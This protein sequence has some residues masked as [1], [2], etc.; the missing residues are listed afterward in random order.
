MSDFLT[1]LAARALHATPVVQPRMASRFEAPHAGQ[2]FVSDETPFS[3]SEKSHESVVPTSPPTSIAHS[4]PHDNARARRNDSDASPLRPVPLRPVPPEQP[5]ANALQHTLTSRETCAEIN[6]PINSPI[7]SLPK[8]EQPVAK[9]LPRGLSTRELQIASVSP[10]EVKTAS[11]IVVKPVIERPVTVDHTARSDASARELLN[12]PIP[13]QSNVSHD[14][15]ENASER[16]SSRDTFVMEPVKP[17]PTAVSQN[18][19]ETPSHQAA[20]IMKSGPLVAIPRLTPLPISA[21]TPSQNLDST[22]AAPTIRVTIG[23]VEVRAIL[24]PAP[25]PPRANPARANSVLSLDE[26]LKQRTE[27]RA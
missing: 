25:A 2:Q 19:S 27:G 17:G 13:V 8:L 20:R 9:E 5:V 18:R 23:R 15:A 4:E 24:P 7:N 1:N 6:S 14:D 16:R 11:P 12:S 10:V 3:E 22:A 21:P 26:Y